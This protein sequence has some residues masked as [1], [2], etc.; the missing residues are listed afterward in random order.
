LSCGINERIR[1]GIQHELD[2]KYR[3][4][5]LHMMGYYS[6]FRK[7]GKQKDIPR[8]VVF[9]SKDVNAEKPDFSAVWHN[10]RQ[11]FEKN[12]HE[13]YYVRYGKYEYAGMLSASLA[14]VGKN[15]TL[16]LK[17]MDEEHTTNW[18]AFVYLMH[19]IDRRNIA[20]LDSIAKKCRDFRLQ[21]GM[22]TLG[23]EAVF[24]DSTLMK[25][26][27]AEEYGSSGKEF[28]KLT[29]YEHEVLYGKA[30]KYKYIASFDGS[31]DTHAWF[32]YTHGS[33][34]RDVVLEKCTSVLERKY[35]P[36]EYK[37]VCHFNYNGISMTDF[38]A[39]F[40]V[41]YFIRSEKDDKQVAKGKISGVY[42]VE[43]GKITPE[44][45]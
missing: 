18:R 43:T 41:N 11:A 25:K 45:I 30:S 21:T 22:N 27:F 8:F 24:V 4:L 12:L 26:I 23:V 36:D 3:E 14:A 2:S 39:S 17:V 7:T 28:S 37:I 13:L 31:P 9:F 32:G 6:I 10:K 16:F 5:G 44:I 42:E 15:Y 1:E 19:H 35:P 40:W 33:P 20:D 29:E 34:F 38:T